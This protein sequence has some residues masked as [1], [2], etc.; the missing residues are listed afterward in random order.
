MQSIHGRAPPRAGAS[1]QGKLLLGQVLPKEFANLGGGLDGGNGPT[2]LGVLGLVER[3]MGTAAA[4]RDAFLHPCAAFLPHPLL[5][6][7]LCR[8]A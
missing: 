4:E 3:P 6:H 5:K 7:G 2:S 1:G 8:A